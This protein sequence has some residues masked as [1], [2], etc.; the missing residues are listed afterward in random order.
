M[1]SSFV[2][3]TAVSGFAETG[4]VVFVVSPG[5]AGEIPAFLLHPQT[6]TEIKN[7][8]NNVFIKC[9]STGLA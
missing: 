7:N 4:V 2:S 1:V 6:I 9:D 5:L 3:F 8:E